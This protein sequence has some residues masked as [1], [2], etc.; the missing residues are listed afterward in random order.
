MAPRLSLQVNVAERS[1]VIV[2][3][4]TNE[5]LPELSPNQQDPKELHFWEGK[6]LKSSTYAKYLSSFVG[7][8]ECDESDTF[9]Q[10]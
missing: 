5:P 6:L 10:P 8:A 9:D 4:I 2:Q 3:Q 7:S 1:T